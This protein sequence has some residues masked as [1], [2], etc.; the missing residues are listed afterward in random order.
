MEP[1][2]PGSLSEGAAERSEAEGVSFDGSTVP[3]VT[4]KPLLALKNL[5]VT[6]IEVHSLSHARWA[7]QLPQGGSRE[8]LYHSSCRSENPGLRAI[9]IAPTK[10]CHLTDRPENGRGAAFLGMGGGSV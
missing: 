4:R 5:Q 2:I 7:C 8:G 6:F 3:M 10:A 9:F 1:A